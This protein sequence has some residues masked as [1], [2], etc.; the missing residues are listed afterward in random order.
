MNFFEQLGV[1]FVFIAIMITIAI[2]IL[3]FSQSVGWL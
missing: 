2:A 1:A 3:S